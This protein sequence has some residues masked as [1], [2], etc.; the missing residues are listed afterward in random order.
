M[1][2]VVR[3]AT[4]GA[5]LAVAQPAWAQSALPLTHPAAPTRTTITPADLMTRLYLYADDSMMGRAA[6]TEYNLKATAYIAAE[7][8]RMGLTPAGD[9]GG[10]F[11]NVPLVK[12]EFDTHSSLAVDGATLRPWD[13]YVP[14]DPRR[15][16]KT[17]S[18]TQVVY[19]GMLGDSTMLTPDQAAGKFII[20]GVR[21][22]P[23]L[24]PSAQ[25]NRGAL[26]GRYRSAAGIAVASLDSMPPGLRAF[27]REPQYALHDGA[28][29]ADTIVL[30]SYVYATFAVAQNMLG[31]PLEGLRAGAVGKT[32]T[33]SVGFSESPAPARNV[34]AILPGGDAALRGEYV[35]IGAHN[36]HVGFDH[37]PVDHDS[38]RAYNGAERRL[39]QAAPGQPVTQEQR[40]QIHVNVDSLHRGRTA[41]PDSIFNGADD[42]GSGTV[43]VLEIAENF[44]GTRVR[45]KRSLIFV[46]HTGEELGLF[47][48]QYFTDHPTVPRDSIV[49]QLNMDMVGRGRAEDETLGGPAYLQLIGTRRLS[50]ELGDLI[51]TV[52]KARRQPFAFDYQ[53]DASGHPEQYYC[54]SDHYMY[55]RYG[56]P[57]AFFTTGGPPRLSPGDRRAAVHRL[58]QAHQRR[59]VRARRRGGGREPGSPR[60][61][62]QAEAG[63][64][65]QLRAVAQPLVRTNEG[66]PRGAPFWSGLRRRRW[67]RATGGTEVFDR[68]IVVDGEMIETSRGAPGRAVTGSDTVVEQHTRLA[69]RS[70]NVVAISDNAVRLGKPDAR[71]PAEQERERLHVERLRRAEGDEY[72]AVVQGGYAAERQGVAHEQRIDGRLACGHFTARQP[73]DPCLGPE[74]LEHQTAG[75]G[76][77]ERVDSIY[78]D[79]R[80]PRWQTSGIVDQDQRVVVR[81]GRFVGNGDLGVPAGQ[82]IAQRQARSVLVVRGAETRGYLGVID[83]RLDGARCDDG[84]TTEDDRDSY[85]H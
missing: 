35:A 1:K 29:P 74:Q 70:R 48:S 10:Y 61:G 39:E 68:P 54:R 72:V 80:V 13:D 45:P 83:D 23:N 65:R 67:R 26:L 8:R 7:V 22:G 18:G 46:W 71:D 49:A 58:R 4:L 53:F 57:I 25:V 62:G 56:I 75:C 30:P 43:A 42:D 69:H 31:A 20:I 34:V 82:E 50:T 84:V 37:T 79:N 19:A 40:A 81:L 32:V 77:W 9:S 11:Q 24:P 2:V 3:V 85:E 78:V 14:R 38:I 12:R 21:C 15:A 51:E 59:A 55:A 41:R 17:L 66:A 47:G 33:G 28:Q 6:G 76:R 16:T 73:L 60:G 64:A 63:S 5:L 27:F 36:D 44:A 52:N